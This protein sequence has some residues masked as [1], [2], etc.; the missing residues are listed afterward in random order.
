MIKNKI[1]STIEFRDKYLMEYGDIFRK[2]I[3]YDQVDKYYIKYNV[4]S[5]YTTKDIIFI[6]KDG[7][8]KKI[9]YA[10]GTVFVITDYEEK[11]LLNE[12]NKR[13][14]HAKFIKKE[15][16]IDKIKRIIKD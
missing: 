1:I 5:R 12:I 3:Y 16:I 11:L 14:P 4:H 9:S 10:S 2:K 13:C 15:R 6:T 8:K 7:K